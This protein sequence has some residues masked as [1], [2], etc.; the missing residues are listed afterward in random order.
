MQIFCGVTPDI[1][2]TRKTCTSKRVTY[3]QKV[4][5]KYTFT[6]KP[7]IT[8]YIFLRP[9]KT[10]IPYMCHQCFQMGVL[11]IHVT[12]LDKCTSASNI[13][14]IGS[15]V[16]WFKGQLWHIKPNTSLLQYLDKA[17]CIMLIP[18]PTHADVFPIIS[19]AV[20]LPVPQL[21]GS[22]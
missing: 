22:Y 8:M 15:L 16:L 2:M 19:Q 6:V 5:D 13:Y 18:L 14:W 20:I 21:A 1:L 9:G 4:S 12:L 10:L 3:L 17:L 11:Y 7:C